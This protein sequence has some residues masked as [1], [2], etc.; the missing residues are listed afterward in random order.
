M[1]LLT[2]KY[3]KRINDGHNNLVSNTLNITF[4]FEFNFFSYKAIARKFAGKNKTV[5]AITKEVGDENMQ[6]FVKG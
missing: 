4:I 6:K 3:I 1:L 5:D 2:R